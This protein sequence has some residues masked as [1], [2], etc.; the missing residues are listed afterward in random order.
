MTE[1]NL[2][3]KI[4]FNEFFT[5]EKTFQKWIIENLGF[6]TS[7]IG[8]SLEDPIPESRVGNYSIDILAKQ[9]DYPEETPSK[10]IIEIQLHKSD[11]DHLGKL[12]TY[13]EN[14]PDVSIAI[15]IAEEF[16]DEHI[17]AL[18]SLNQKLS[19]VQNRNKVS[20]YALSPHLLKI[21]EAIGFQFQ[22]HVEPKDRKITTKQEA[23]KEFNGYLIEEFHRLQPTWRRLSPSKDNWQTF[24]TGRKG[25]SFGW[26]YQKEHLAIEL[27][28]ELGDLEGIEGN[29]LMAKIK[30]IYERNPNPELDLEWDRKVGK[31]GCRVFSKEEI[32]ELVEITSLEEKQR[33]AKNGARVLNCMFLAFKDIIPEN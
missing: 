15:W 31:K 21:D 4:S 10:V 26:R 22:V 13:S 5:N 28:F 23:Y 24:S 20:Y 19:L 3:E 14:E 6:I 27:Y 1:L 8:I 32:S 18:N 30:E 9:T 7:A 17:Q 12:I 29:R 11:H 25:I 33:I 16:T 2:V